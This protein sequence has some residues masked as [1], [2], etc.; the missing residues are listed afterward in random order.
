MKKTVLFTSIALILCSCS[1][2]DN[3]ESETNNS[4]IE[5]QKVLI[6]NKSDVKNYIFEGKKL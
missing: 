5:N 3:L 2:N 4:G 6:V 1:K